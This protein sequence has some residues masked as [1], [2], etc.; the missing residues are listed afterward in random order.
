MQQE[1][2]AEE[3]TCSSRHREMKIAPDTTATRS[4]CCPNRLSNDK[5]QC[6]FQNKLYFSAYF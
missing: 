6:K 4:N 2:C 5:F 3:K 1:L